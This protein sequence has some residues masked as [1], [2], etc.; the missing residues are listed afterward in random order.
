M[1]TISI[2]IVE[3]IKYIY[4][5]ILVEENTSDKVFEQFYRKN[6]FT[7]REKSIITSEV[8]SLLRNWRYLHEIQNTLAIINKDDFYILYEIHCIITGIAIPPS[9]K[10]SNINRN[11]V[12]Q[13]VTSFKG[14]VAI[15]HS[16]PD[17]L[18]EHC[19]KELGDVWTSMSKNLILDAPL[20]IRVNTEKITRD[21]LQLQFKEKGFYSLP[22]KA[23]INA[24]VLKQKIN[25]F[26]LPEFKEGCFEVQD[27]SSQMVSHFLNPQPGWRIIDGCAGNGG[28]TLHLANLMHNRGKIISL[29]IYQF[30]LDTLKKRARRAGS[31]IIETRLVNSTKVIKRLYGTADAVLLDVPCTGLGVL[32][33]NPEIKWRLKPADLENLLKT[34]AD[35]LSRYSRMVKPGGKLVYSTCSILPSENSLQIRKFVANASGDFEF[36]SDQFLSPENG[37]DGFYMAEMKRKP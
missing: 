29:D 4:E 33:R 11:K 14:N 35:L 1:L 5:Q 18:N 2:Q 13:I 32:K 9:Q 37:F 3:A 25:V 12:Q 7:E 8:Y 30:K 6:Q 16:I 23:A 22:H 26:K 20:V 17:W 34:Q 27:I 24:L 21:K 31:S 36:V 28:K 10:F 19:L 15:E